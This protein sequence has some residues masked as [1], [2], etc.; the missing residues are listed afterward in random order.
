MSIRATVLG[1]IILW[2]IICVLVSSAWAGGMDPRMDPKGAK[3]V[4][5]TQGIDGVIVKFKGEMNEAKAVAAGER[6]T[7]TAGVPLRYE[8]QFL[9]G[10]VVYRLP[11]PRSEAAVKALVKK[12]AADPTIEYVEPDSVMTIQ[13]PR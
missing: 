2:A 5:Q 1:L 7:K 10:E 3:A 8:R 9:G 4:Q 12:L 11:G 6:L 13:K